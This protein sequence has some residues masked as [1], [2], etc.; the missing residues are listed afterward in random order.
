[1]S[2][3]A[4]F[5][6]HN[7]TKHTIEKLL[8]SP[9]Y[10]DWANQPNPF[11]IYHE[12]SSIKLSH[13]LSVSSKSYFDVIE[14]I[15]C[16]NRS[17]SVPKQSTE[18][19]G[20]SA[21]FVS[22]LLFY[23]TAI[24][25]WK[26]IRGTN[27]RWALR[28]NASSGNLHPTE[29]YIL[30]NNIDGLEAGLYH[31]RA[32]NH[33][34]EIR[35]N[36]THAQLSWQI[37]AGNTIACPPLLIC[38]NSIY[39]REVWKYRERGFRY[40]QHD[41][42]HALASVCIA[43]ASFGYYS[44]TF[45]LFPDR[46]MSR[47]LGANNGDEKPSLFIALWP[48]H[49]V[50][51]NSFAHILDYNAHLLVDLKRVAGAIDEVSFSGNPNILSKE[52]IEYALVDEIETITETTVESFQD[53]REKR[54]H[55]TSR[56]G[57][58]QNENSAYAN[59]SSSPNLDPLDDPM[60]VAYLNQSKQAV[61]NSIHQTIRRRRSAVDFDGQ[62]RMSLSHLGIILAS[63]TRGFSADF[64]KS[65]PLS[66]TKPHQKAHH[67]IHL[68]LYVHRVDG[69]APGVYYYDRSKQNLIPFAYG[70]Q[71]ELAKVMSCIQDI[72]A[73]GCLALSMVADFHLMYELY[74]DRSYR[75]IHYEAGFIGQHLYLAATALGYEAT[76][77]GCFVDD[78]INT[79]LKL[80][81]GNEVVYNFTIGSAVQDPR[82]TTL[83]AYDFL[84]P[85]DI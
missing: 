37:L 56:F 5:R 81:P 62:K 29:T 55:L 54:I 82:L 74:G 40:C 53:F 26:Q 34:L 33:S 85:S 41:L 64:Q 63:A 38:L 51:E 71:R 68:Y 76:G 48:Y 43:A 22:N 12:S 69:A 21:Q 47:L 42:G 30:A 35:S 8:Y 9:H 79:Y 84:E 10:L 14:D 27:Q 18:V 72:A 3:S 1:M 39:W 49:A 28:V 4:F 70:D 44:F 67:L 19:H 23:S 25:A 66:T 15:D 80:K 78:A 77:I 17:K 50:P 45:G 57:R 11:R 60:P 46:L 7:Q 20:A 2:N 13:D 61:D 52:K 58:Q 36:G 31:Y 59:L 32:D 24:S 73:D 16:W 6:Y 75:L 83:P 65:S